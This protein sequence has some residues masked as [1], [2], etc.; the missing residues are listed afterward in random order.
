MISASL[1]MRVADI[2]Q[3]P[4]IRCCR[5]SPPRARIRNPEHPVRIGF[6]RR[7]GVE[8]A[9]QP[10]PAADSHQESG[11]PREDRVRPK[12]GVEVAE[13]PRPARNPHMC[14]LHE[15]KRG[16][17]WFAMARRPFRRSIEDH[18]ILRDEK[19]ARQAPQFSFCNCLFI[20]PPS[21]PPTSQA[22]APGQQGR[23]AAAQS[24]PYTL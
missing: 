23:K 21:N 22:I 1:M 19:I 16:H 4:E 24:L 5:K 12:G 6:D 9:E 7:G 3:R 10:R 2:A 8:V 11:A 14:F 17:H 18:P 20:R 13:Q 15:T